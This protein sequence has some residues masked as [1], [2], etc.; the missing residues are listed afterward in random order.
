MQLYTP[1][2]AGP[3]KESRLQPRGTVDLHA[4]APSDSSVAVRQP[5]STC[6]CSSRRSA[7]AHRRSDCR[8]LIELAHALSTWLRCQDACYSGQWADRCSVPGTS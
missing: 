8:L 6:L 3:V 4:A 5:K 1:P 2:G 7:H